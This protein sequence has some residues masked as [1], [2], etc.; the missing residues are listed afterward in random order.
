VL[1]A[2]DEGSFPVNMVVSPDGE[3]AIT[4]D[5]GYRQAI[6]AVRLSDGTGTGQIPFPNKTMFRDSSGHSGKLVRDE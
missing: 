3:F 6:W 4:S 5:I 2:Q 1:H